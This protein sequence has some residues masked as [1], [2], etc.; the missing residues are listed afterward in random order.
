[1]QK[2]YIINENLQR[3]REISAVYNPVTGEGS[4]SVA[5][6]WTTFKGFPIERINLPLSMIGDEEIQRLSILGVHEYLREVAGLEPNDR[7]IIRFIS[8]SHK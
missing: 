8:I 7:N 3:L 1:M 5:R 6:Q 2:E 4:I